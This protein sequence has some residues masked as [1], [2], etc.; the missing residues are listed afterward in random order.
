VTQDVGPTTARR[1][2]DNPP[3]H[4]ALC[5]ITFAESARWTIATP[6]QIYEKFRQDYPAEPKKQVDLQA[7]LPVTRPGPGVSG[8]ELT[9]GQEMLRLADQEDRRL[10]LVSP[11]HISV[12][13]TRP[14]EGWESLEQRLRGGISRL[15]EVYNPGPVQNIGLRYINRV[16]IKGD[17]LD[18]DDYFNIAIPTPPPMLGG[19]VRSF[20]Y[21]LEMQDAKHPLSYKQ[22]FASLAPE[23]DDVAEFLLDLDFTYEPPDPTSIE[24]SLRLANETKAVENTIF[25][26]LITDKCRELFADA[27]DH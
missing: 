26:A 10:V 20:F 11:N 14:Y 16:R 8:V 2:Y 25:E 21:R 1:V 18:L 9:Q 22:T 15:S 17:T 19:Q 5:R 23:P 7:V 3:I 27:K 13:S 24:E 6:G 12:H 4:E